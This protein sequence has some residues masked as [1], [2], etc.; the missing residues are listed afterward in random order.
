MNQTTSSSQG[1]QFP[2]GSQAGEG[3]ERQ[4]GTEKDRRVS[5]SVTCEQRSGKVEQEVLQLSE[6]KPF[7]CKGPEAGTRLSGPEQ[8]QGTPESL[9][10]SASQPRKGTWKGWGS[11]L[12]RRSRDRLEEVFLFFLSFFVSLPPGLSC[13]T[14]DLS[15]WHVGWYK[16]Q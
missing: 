14:Q 9:L 12:N 10:S 8:A 11:R 4:G 2:R 15:L 13:G 3:A 5:P 7:R 16:R 6:N 1:V